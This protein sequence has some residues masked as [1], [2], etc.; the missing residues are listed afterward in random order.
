MAGQP[1]N[2]MLRLRL[3]F[4]AA[5]LASLGARRASGQ[6]ATA[7][8]QLDC[9][10]LD[11]E[12]RAALE[13]R[14]RAEIV[15]EPLPAGSLSIRCAPRAV[16]VAW[17][18]TDTEQRERTVTFEST[19]DVDAVLEAIHLLRAPAARLPTVAPSTIAPPP[20]PAYDSPP[21]LPDPQP[22]AASS[23]RFAAVTTLDVELWQGGIVG[24]LGGSAGARL[25]ADRWRATLLV[26]P[27]RG[28]GSAMGV[29]AWELRG[30]AQVDYAVTESWLFGLGITGRSLWAQASKAAPSEQH[31]TTAGAQIASRYAVRLGSFELAAGPRA[32]IVFRPIAIRVDQSEAF[33]IPALVVGAVIDASF[34]AAPARR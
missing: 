5:I 10:E 15:S 2:E 3:A 25:L 20:L 22:P 34:P 23:A 32:E 6:E 18:A 29:S 11:G 31:A 4:A 1:W 28:V 13:A 30:V 16:T 8:L 24:A 12:T 33:R 9:R 7:S 14:A 17:R 21:P 19:A 27:E 26:G